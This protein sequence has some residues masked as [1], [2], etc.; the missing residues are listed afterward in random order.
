[1]TKIIK[2]HPVDP[3]LMKNLLPCFH[4]ADRAETV[5]YILEEGGTSGTMVCDDK[6]F[7]IIGGSYTGPNTVF[8]WSLLDVEVKNHSLFFYKTMKKFMY[9]YFKDESLLRIYTTVNSD[10]EK[11]IEQNLSMGLTKEGVMRKAGN[12]GQDIVVF[13]L[14]RGDHGC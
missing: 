6:P 4:E 3:Y 14:V 9:D 13:S 2:A 10:N 7:A 11:A 12:Q 1:M 5:K 8:C